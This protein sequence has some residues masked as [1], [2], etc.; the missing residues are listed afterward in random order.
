MKDRTIVLDI[1][2]TDS[3]GRRYNIEMQVERDSTFIPRVIFYH[4]QL[5]VSQLA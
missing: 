2:T 4:D 5:Y 1:A 3:Q